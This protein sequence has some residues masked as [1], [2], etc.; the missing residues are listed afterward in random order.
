M[1]FSTIIVLLLAAAAKAEDQTTV[2]AKPV[3][4]LSEDNKAE[5]D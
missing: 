1:R 3:S 4:F 5:I 2:S